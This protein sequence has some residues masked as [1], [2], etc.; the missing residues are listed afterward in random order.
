MIAKPVK[1]KALEKYLIWLKY[2]DGT[3]GTVDI[4]D[5]AGKGIFKIWD[6]NNNFSN[7][8]INKETDGIAWSDEVEI[9]PETVYLQIRKPIVKKHTRLKQAV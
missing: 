3:E 9:D 8:Y 1:V 7:A 2:D 4:S 6:K 5:V